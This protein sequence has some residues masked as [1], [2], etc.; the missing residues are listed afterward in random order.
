MSAA[1]TVYTAQV[2]RSPPRPSSEQASRASLR[3]MQA[4]ARLTIRVRER[5]GRSEE[6]MAREDEGDGRWGS[7]M[8]AH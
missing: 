1:H 4:C 5:G 3:L 6:G 2:E 7:M 8:Q